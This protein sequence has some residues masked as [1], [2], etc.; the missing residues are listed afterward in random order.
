MSPIFALLFGIL[1]A[2]SKKFYV[3]DKSN[4]AQL[5]DKFSDNQLTGNQI[6]IENDN[7]KRIKIYEC[8]LE[9]YFKNGWHAIAAK[10][11]E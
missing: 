3:T 5:G 11:E 8:E 10:D 4:T 9:Y 1:D 7:G 6:L 2:I